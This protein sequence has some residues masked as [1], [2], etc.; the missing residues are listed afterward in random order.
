MLRRW[1]AGRG[2][3]GKKAENRGMCVRERQRC[4]WQARQKVVAEASMVWQAEAW[5]HKGGVMACIMQARHYAAGGREWRP[6]PPE[7]Q[8]AG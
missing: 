2:G 3:T 1:K 6:P 8:E 7:N 4:V 5:Q